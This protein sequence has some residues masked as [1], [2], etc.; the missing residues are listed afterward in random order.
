MAGFDERNTQV[1]NA[2]IEFLREEGDD[3]TNAEQPKSRVPKSGSVFA[4]EQE[5]SGSGRITHSRMRRTYS[6]SLGSKMK[7]ARPDTI[8][9]CD[10]CLRRARAFRKACVASKSQVDRWQ[11]LATARFP[12]L[13]SLKYSIVIHNSRP[14]QDT[15][16]ILASTVQIQGWDL[17]VVGIRGFAMSVVWTLNASSAGA[18]HAPSIEDKIWDGEGTSVSATVS[19]T[20]GAGRGSQQTRMLALRIISRR[21]SLQ[22]YLWARTARG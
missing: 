4:A 21:H 5:R 20:V 15:C 3:V 14:T 9:T 12:I 13:G 19:R 17:T 11:C 18:R 7:L 22:R 6:F 10:L 1:P 2:L 8:R 16:I